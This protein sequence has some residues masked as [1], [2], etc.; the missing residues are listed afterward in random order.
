M[1]NLRFNT[2]IA[3]LIELNNALVGERNLPRAVAEAIVLMLAP[4]APHLSEELW[5]TLGHERSLGAAPWPSWEEKYLAETEI[6]IVVQVMGKV[7]GKVLVP[8]DAGEDAV[9]EKAVADPNVSKFLAGKTV[10]KVVFV[11][12]RLINIVAN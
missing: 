12:G 8:P 7:R 10:R 6:E 2:A 9:R 1:E 4:L 11:P 5:E 3:G